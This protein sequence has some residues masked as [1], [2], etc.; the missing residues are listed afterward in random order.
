MTT[1]TKK[2]LLDGVG[3]QSLLT[4]N[5]PKL[6]KGEKQGYLTS[7]IHL[8]PST[9]SGV[10]TCP[11]ASAGCASACLNK[12]GH[13]GIG[14]DVD[15]LNKI[16]RIRI[17][18]TQLLF[19]DRSRWLAIFEREMRIFLRKADRLGLIPVF[20]PNITSD[21]QWEKIAVTRDGVTYRNMFQAYPEVQFY[22]YT[23]FPA[24][25]RE[26]AIKNYHLTFS[27]KEGNDAIA[28][29]ALS[30]GLNVAV[31]IRAK[32]HALPATFSGLPVIDGDLDDLRFLDPKGG[33]IVGLSPKGNG[34]MRDTSGFIRDVDSAIGGP[35]REGWFYYDGRIIIAA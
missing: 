4:K 18:R 26:T 8:A 12:A 20:R 25:R 9:M 35:A 17:A 31:A 11:F 10:N 19:S 3:F 2:Q 23:A 14:L 28:L 33:H 27:L 15:G 5:Q 29:Q 34:A 1:K 32:K 30:A 22:D 21:I 16:Q 6:K 7:G 24:H 13:G